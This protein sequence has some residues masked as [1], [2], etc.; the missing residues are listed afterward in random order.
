MNKR[1][2]D[3]INEILEIAKDTKDYFKV[4]SLVANIVDEVILLEEKSKLIPCKIRMPLE[5]ILVS[6][7]DFSTT[8]KTE[9]VL[10]QTK[11]GDM[12]IAEFRR[13]CLKIPDGMMSVVGIH[14][15]LVAE[16]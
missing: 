6:Q 1:F 11:Q 9:K 4:K 16:E 8:H 14:M 12:F 3:S 7:S 13:T 2:N 10:V 15:E 5:N